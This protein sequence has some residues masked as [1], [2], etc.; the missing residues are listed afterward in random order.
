MGYIWK[1]LDDKNFLYV[2]NHISLHP[3]LSGLSQNPYIK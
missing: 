1:I 2:F 3:L